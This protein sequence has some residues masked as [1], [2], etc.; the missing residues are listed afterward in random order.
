MNKIVFE[1]CAEDRARLD[2]LADNLE[3][4]APQTVNFNFE[5]LKQATPPAVPQEAPKEE[6][7]ENNNPAEEPTLEA[8]TEDT[9][10]TQ[11]DKPELNITLDHIRQKVMDIAASNG[12]AKKAQVRAVISAY[13]SKVTD[14][15]DQPDKWA[16][17]WEKLTA[18]EREV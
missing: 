4:A 14:L 17:V 5:N 8:T 18:L 13:G 10:P 3:K 1:L 16:E 6:P 7:K 2:R 12:G 9:A 15:K 11:E